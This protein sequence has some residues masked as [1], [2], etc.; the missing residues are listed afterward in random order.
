MDTLIDTACPQAK[1]TLQRHRHKPL[2]LKKRSRASTGA[3][4]AP[5]TR[6]DAMGFVASAPAHATALV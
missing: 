4:H 5:Q 2:I 6:L 1:N 3:F